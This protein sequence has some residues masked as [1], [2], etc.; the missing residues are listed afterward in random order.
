MSPPKP[1]RE[2]YLNADSATLDRHARG[3]SMPK[4]RI[5]ECSV[6]IKPLSPA[7]IGDGEHIINEDR[8]DDVDGH[9]SDISMEGREEAEN[10]QHTPVIKNTSYQTPYPTILLCHIGVLCL[11]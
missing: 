5:L 11:Q 9:E 3:L 1:A 8:R 7:Q 4:R 10:V 6:E 2:I